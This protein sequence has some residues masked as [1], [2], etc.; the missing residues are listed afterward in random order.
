MKCLWCWRSHCHEGVMPLG[1]DSVFT[2]THQHWYTQIHTLTHKL[3]VVNVGSCCLL[4]WGGCSLYLIPVEL[5]SRLCVHHCRT[6]CT[7]KWRAENMKQERDPIWKKNFFSIYNQNSSNDLRFSPLHSIWCSN[8]LELQL[9]CA[10]L[11]IHFAWNDC[12]LW[13]R[14]IQFYL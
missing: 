2:L 3:M 1:Q 11:S 13:N 12:L 7:K 10:F 4:G 8:R 14:L 9:I 5:S 6:G